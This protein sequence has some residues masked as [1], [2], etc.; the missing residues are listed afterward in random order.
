MRIGIFLIVLLLPV[1]GG[2]E[3]WKSNG[4]YGG[5]FQSFLFHPTDPNL[6]FA[7][8]LDGL[9]R[10]TDTGKNWTRVDLTGGEFVVR[11]HRSNPKLILAAAS[12]RGIFQS[13]DQ[14]TSWQQFYSYEFRND[15]FY[16]LEFHP[17]DPKV[18]YAVSYY[19]GVFKSTDGGLSWTARNNGLKLKPLRDCCVDLPQLE[20][21]PS[22]GKTLYVLL[23][24]RLVYRSNNGGET[25]QPANHGLDFTKEVH[26]LTIDPRN[27]LVLYA[28]GANGIFRSINGGQQ[29][30]TRRCGC[31]VWSFAVNPHNAKEV[32]GV[33][34]GAVKSD[35]GGKSWEWFSPH[36]F[37]SGI[38]LGVAVHPSNPNIVLV[39]GFGG[40]I[41]RSTDAGRSWETVNNT[42]DALN[43][44]RLVA[45]PATPGRLFAVGGQQ[46]FES[47][48][49]GKTW[50]LFLKSQGST[51]WVSDLAV[52]PA[53]PKLIVAA[54]YRKSP[55]ALTLSADGGKT[56]VTRSSFSGVNYGCS[57]CVALD[58]AN[59][60]IL[61]IAPFDKKKDVVTQLGVARSTDQGKTWTLINKGLAPRDIWMLAVSPFDSSAIYAGTGTGALFRTTD[62]GQS[63]SSADHGLD[64]G[65]VRAI[66][67]NRSD[68]NIVYLSTYSAIFKSTDAGLTWMRKSEGMPKSAWL[69]FVEAD[70]QSPDTLIA[71]GEAGLFISRDGAEH[72]ESFEGGGPGNFAVWNFVSDPSNRNRHYA[73][74]DRGVFV[75]DQADAR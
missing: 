9:F 52:H 68:K 19:N 34:E 48:D 74:T 65:S 25:W 7:S 54:G 63:W 12:S 11:V 18:L 55:G 8:G 40:G 17:Q 44:V 32:Y 2:A 49:G 75:M 1:A 16:D 22:N 23:P 58:P 60:D 29:W 31:Y 43:V 61:Y 6:V 37:L 62:S 20:V 3:D 21:D 53:N 51:F 10:S 35:D 72:W 56:W 24:S 59:P 66:T 36:P 13:T 4:P 42:L 15:A 39:G 14:G 46:A 73:G 5:S 64:G 71:A 47:R 41:Y 28:G 70:P 67:F 26:A 27:T 33:G 50:D 57:N 69:N 38:L 45:D 30:L